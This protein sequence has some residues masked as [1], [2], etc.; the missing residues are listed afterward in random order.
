[1]RCDAARKD[2]TLD[3]IGLAKKPQPTGTPSS[4]KYRVAGRVVSVNRICGG[5]AAITPEMVAQLPPPQP[6]VGKVLLVVAGENIGPVPEVARITTGADGQFDIRLSH[7]A[8]CVFDAGRKLDGTE[9]VRAPDLV[10]PSANPNIDEACLAV[11]RRRCD[12]I[13]RVAEKDQTGLQISFYGS[14]PEVYN[15]PCYRGP[16]PP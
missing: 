12:E 1:V 4:K 7:G 13:I 3:A 9:K 14:C 8:W 6:L 16:M 10:L 2:P 15:Q 11:E 5:G